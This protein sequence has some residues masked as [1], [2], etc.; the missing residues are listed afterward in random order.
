MPQA[1]QLPELKKLAEEFLSAVRAAAYA[2]TA[3]APPNENI[4]GA[5]VVSGVSVTSSRF[6]AAA[7]SSPD[8]AK[9]IMA[10]PEL[11]ALELASPELAR[12]AQE[13]PELAELAVVSPNLARVASKAPELADLARASPALAAEIEVQLAR[14]QGR[15]PG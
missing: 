12:L 10:S 3:G 15:L 5:Q 7:A 6:T 2:L 8:L 9:A 14:L 1:G 11:A 4:S 13:N